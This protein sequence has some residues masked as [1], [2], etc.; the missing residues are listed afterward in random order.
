VRILVTGATGFVGRWLTEEFLA[1]GHHVIAAPGSR[2]LD[3]T[4]A[5]AVSNLVR[6][7]GPEAIAHLAGIAY[8][9]DASRD[10]ARALEVN[11]GGTRA[12]VEAAAAAGRVPVLVSG[13]SDVYGTPDQ[14]DLPLRESAPLRAAKPYGLSKLAQERAAVEEGHRLGVPVVV[15]RSFNHTGPGQRPD[16]V[17]PALAARILQ[18][19][20]EGDDEVVVG[21]L[22]VRR[23][24]GDV[25]DV[26]RAYR[27]LLEGLASAQVP[28]GSIVNVA[29]GLHVSIREVFELICDI[30]GVQVTPRVDP[31]LLRA[32]DPGLIV[33]SAD[34]LRHLTGWS[35]RISLDQ[36]L[37]DL[38]ESLR[39][40]DG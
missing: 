36:T 35:P 32:N 29:T 3:I 31:D 34:R 23:D 30:A 11:V 39:V 19:K 15:T 8:A 12:V 33:G 20:V 7:A 13:S 22:D 40:V 10:P 6:A 28:D 27:L 26:A 5:G 18:A 4:D 16:F 1:N 14:A 38:V 2:E 21:A 17:A 25:R 9:G 24:I 37:R